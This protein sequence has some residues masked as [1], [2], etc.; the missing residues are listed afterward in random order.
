VLPLPSSP[1]QSKLSHHPRLRTKKLLIQSLPVQRLARSP[2]QA[3]QYQLRHPMATI[4]VRHK[5]PTPTKCSNA[6]FQSRPTPRWAHVTTITRLPRPGVR[7][8]AGLGRS[9]IQ[10]ISTC[11]LLITRT[12]LPPVPSPRHMC[13]VWIRS[14]LT[15]SPQRTVP[16]T[17]RQMWSMRPH[18]IRCL[19]MTQLHIP[20]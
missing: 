7:P 8:Q 13:L 15:H 17:G 16:R 1:G 6:L 20:H 3:R 10:R 18:L 14:S 4:V 19:I 12:Q 9:L 2:P 11:T 5:A